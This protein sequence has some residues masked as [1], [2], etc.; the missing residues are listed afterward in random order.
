MFGSCGINPLFIS[1]A[2]LIL[3]KFHQIGFNKIIDVT[4]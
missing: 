3:T 2:V 4:I 1:K